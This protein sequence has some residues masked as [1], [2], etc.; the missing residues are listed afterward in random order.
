MNARTQLIKFTAVW[1]T[2]FIVCSILSAFAYS[3]DDPKSGTPDD[4][5]DPK[6]ADKTKDDDSDKDPDKVD[7]DDEP[8]D[9]TTNPD[10]GT[11][12]A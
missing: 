8:K 6:V 7:P 9:P 12:Y 10:D 11:P 5:D 2:V 3:S 1:L 4:R